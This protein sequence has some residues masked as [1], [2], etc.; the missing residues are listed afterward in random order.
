MNAQNH[1]DQLLTT[2]EAARLLGVSVDT[3]RSLHRQGR[4]PAIRTTG[5]Q[6]RF[7]KE[8]V[9]AV[10]A[11]MSGGGV[12]GGQADARAAIA[13]APTYPIHAT[14]VMGH[15]RRAP[16][17][18]EFL[19]ECDPELIVAQAALEGLRIRHDSDTLSRQMEQEAQEAAKGVEAEH[20]AQQTRQRLEDLKVHGRWLASDL[21]TEWRQRVVSDLETHV[22]TKDFPPSLPEWEARTFV[23]ARVQQVRNRYLAELARQD[24]EVREQMHMEILKWFG[25]DAARAQTK[26]WDSE[27]AEDARREIDDELERRVLPGWTE[28]DVNRLVKSHL[29]TWEEVDDTEEADDEDEE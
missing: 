21:P 4:L 24:E 1:D 13:S 20:I 17:R 22:T 7:R 12:G 3:V 27:D 11:G 6:R 16:R 10:G 15:F 8:D 14:P 18:M 9:M 2:G 25:R 5:G 28:A 23:A 19:D 29:A 26:D